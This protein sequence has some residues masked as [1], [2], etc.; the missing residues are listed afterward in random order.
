M[1][2]EVGPEIPEGVGSEA[3][4]CFSASSTVIDPRAKY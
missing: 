1:I 4:G 2:N 3:Y